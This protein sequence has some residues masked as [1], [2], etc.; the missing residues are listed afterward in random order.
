MSR[1]FIKYRIEQ[2][3]ALFHASSNDERRLRELLAELNRRT[4][5]RASL[6][7]TRVEQALAARAAGPSPARP[8][9]RAGPPPFPPPS[10]LP[11]TLEPRRSADGVPKAPISRDAADRTSPAQLLDAWTALEVLSPQT[12]NKPEDLVAGD[13]ARIARFGEGALPWEGAGEK[14]RPKRLLYYQVVLGELDLPAAYDALFRRFADSAPERQPPRGSVALAVVVCDQRGRLTQDSVAVS[15]FGWGLPVACSGHLTRLGNWRTEERRIVDGLARRLSDGEDGAALTRRALGDAFRWLVAELGLDRA[16]VRAPWFAVREYQFMFLPEPPEPLLLNS[17][18]LGDLARARA[19]LDSNVAPASL[20]RYLGVTAPTVQHDVLRDAQTLMRLLKPSATPCARWPGPRRESLVTL[21]QAAVNAAMN[22]AP[23]D[24]IA[25]NGPPGTGKT[26]LLRDIVAAVVTA[27]AEVLASYD[28]PE[29]AFTPAGVTFTR[30]GTRVH[31]QRLASNL[32]GFEMVVASSNNKAVENV[33]A[34]LPGA[35]AIAADMPRLRY[36][37][38]L[39]SALRG[40]ECWGLVAAVLGNSS[41]RYEFQKT[42]WDDEDRGLEA[43]LAAAGGTPRQVSGEG[44]EARLPRIVAQESPPSGHVEALVRWRAAKERFRSALKSSRDVVAA[45]QRVDEL[46]SEV[47]RRSAQLVRLKQQ[48]EHAHL[49]VEAAAHA[50]ADIEVRAKAHG[51]MLADLK[52]AREQLRQQQPGFFARLFRTATARPWLSENR[53]LTVR[54]EAAS[55]QVER[56]LSGVRDARTRYEEA[57]GR[58]QELEQLTAQE[59][60]SIAD[61]ERQLFDASKGLA[62]FTGSRLR[63]AP[64]AERHL[65]TAW[66]DAKA[67]RARDEVFAAAMALHKAFIDAAAVPLRHNLAGLMRE[68]WTGV[69]GADAGLIRELWASLFLVVPLVS[70]TF[71]SVEKMFGSLPL[72][73]LGWLLID[74]AGQATPQSAVGA[75]MRANR[76]VV[77]GDPMQVEPVVLLPESLTAA[78][79]SRFGVDVTKFAAPSASVQTLADHVSPIVATFDGRA[80]A[81]TVGIPLL[82]HRRCAEPMFGI[83]NGVAYE[84]LMVNAKAPGESAIGAVLGHSQWL[85]VEGSSASHWCA[86]EG[87]LMVELLRTLERRSVSP[88]LYIVTPFRAVAQEAGELIRRSGVLRTVTDVERFIRERIGTIH[89][90]QGREAEALI[91]VLGAPEPRQA[92][93]RAWAGARPNLLNV[94]VTRAKERLYVIGNRKLWR[95]A[96]YFRVLDE[97]LPPGDSGLGDGVGDPRKIDA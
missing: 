28:D 71:A 86:E 20:Q 9:A 15:S 92:S 4:T 51:E 53:E 32:H 7:K 18:F 83:S 42:F 88:D 31:L 57:L 16:F 95:T 6:L 36:F 97:R 89:K 72:S 78:I 56:A 10:A 30:A 82:V 45:L 17:F 33:S 47:L 52:T 66:F 79:C 96:G 11:A 87:T 21:Q 38:S 41:N 73:S 75:V 22:S 43:Y 23:G 3:E 40:E 1:P 14:S 26:T 54:V 24:V 58:R 55:E 29:S 13:R 81:R 59:A 35:R 49:A 63:S 84:R 19:S 34:E 69:P 67:H 80:G 93:A 74:E 12:F 91:F 5:R 39:A 61:A 77:V 48:R 8:Q 65:A 70:T 94:A 27:R 85:H 60:Q 68:M 25:V 62:A 64:H 37:A 90:V 46:D 44:G 2:L 50:L 76:T